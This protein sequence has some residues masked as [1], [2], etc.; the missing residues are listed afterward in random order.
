MTWNGRLSMKYDTQCFADNNKLFFSRFS[1]MISKNCCSIQ[2]SSGFFKKDRV[3]CFSQTNSYG[4]TLKQ[5]FHVCAKVLSFVR[6]GNFK[7]LD[8][9]VTESNPWGR[10]RGKQLRKEKSLCLRFRVVW[11]V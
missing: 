11:D 4:A 6:G 1:N 7:V 10:S 2:F 3:K 8:L 5:R 9:I